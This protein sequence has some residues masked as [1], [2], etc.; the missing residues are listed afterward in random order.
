MHLRHR[1]V[2][3]GFAATLALTPVTA[4]VTGYLAA[5]VSVA[6]PTANSAATTAG[7]WLASQFVKGQYYANPNTGT[8]D[9][10][11][12]ADAL[13]GLVASGTG[14]NTAKTVDAWLKTKASSV[15][16]AG[17]L[18][19]LVIA[20]AAMGDDPTAY[21]GVDLVAKL[22]AAVTA[23]GS[24]L[25]NPYT[26]SLLIIALSRAGATVPTSLVDALVTRQNAEGEF[27]FG[28]VGASD[29]FADPDSTGLALSAL[30]LVSSPAAKA[31]V[32]RGVAWAQKNEKSAGYW[33]SYSPVNTTGL[34]GSALKSHGVDVSKAVAWMIGQQ[35]KA[36]GKGLPAALDDPTPDA[37]ATAQGLLLLG[38]VSLA[39]VKFVGAAPSASAPPTTPPLPATGD[40]GDG[41]SEAG[42]LMLLGGGSV[43]A[44]GGAAAARLR[45]RSDR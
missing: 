22:T 40:G 38:G 28:T 15:T 24:D 35:A 45:R 11:G 14:Q 25:S 6:A 4:A 26:D 34:V 5:P 20:A 8:A 23:T 32:T 7:T 21:G 44:L 17:Q 19:K 16:S 1:L 13:V 12:T 36:G 9:V 43:I 30:S 41:T 3:A 33:D 2:A 29:Y 10:A 27:Y 42:L 37:Y 31:A 18:A 39:T